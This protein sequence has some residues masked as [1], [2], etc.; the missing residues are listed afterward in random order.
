MHFAHP[1]TPSPGR[2]LNFKLGWHFRAM[3]Q[4]LR[5]QGLC[6][7][8]SLM[9]FGTIAAKAT[10]RHTN[11][12]YWPWLWLCLCLPWL[13]GGAWQCREVIKNQHGASRAPC[14]RI[15]I[16]IFI[17]YPHF[18]SIFSICNQFNFND[19]T[20]AW[21]RWMGWIQLN[22]LHSTIG[23]ILCKY[24][25]RKC[26]L[27][28]FWFC[29]EWDEWMKTEAAP[30]HSLLTSSP[31]LEPLTWKSSSKSG[32]GWGPSRNRIRLPHA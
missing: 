15:R 1:L 9:A 30:C 12:N 32:G 16:C 23:R 21:S 10:L 25:N 26:K 19:R 17:G 31:L 29:L 2:L 6:L 5:V 18:K 20:F 7:W 4:G 13:T 28:E 27:V 14:I 22:G 24:A 11:C 8:F 3:C